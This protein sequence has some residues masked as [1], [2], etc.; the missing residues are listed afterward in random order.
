[1]RF[2]PIFKNKKVVIHKK[3][4]NEVYVKFNYA[5]NN[6]K[7]IQYLLQYMELLLKNIDFLKN[8][9]DINLIRVFFIK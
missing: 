4:G 2:N 9:R 6:V 5:S 1:M 8:F 3:Y 7:L